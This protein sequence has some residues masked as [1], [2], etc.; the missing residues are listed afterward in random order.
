[1]TDHHRKLSLKYVVVT[2]TCITLMR[3]LHDL[4]HVSGASKAVTVKVT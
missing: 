2:A 4:M 1:M 3:K